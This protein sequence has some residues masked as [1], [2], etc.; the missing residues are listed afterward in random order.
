MQYLLLYSI[1]EELLLDWQAVECL[2][3]LLW[4]YLCLRILAFA[5]F[6]SFPYDLLHLRERLVVVRPDELDG[7]HYWGYRCHVALYLDR[8]LVKHIAAQAYRGGQLHRLWWL[9][10]FIQTVVIPGR[11]LL[12]F[13]AVTVEPQRLKVDVR[14]VVGLGILI[15]L[16]CKGYLGQS[17]LLAVRRGVWYACLVLLP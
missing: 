3:L 2:F 14:L 15:L 4:R 17:F 12:A 16:L 6:F 1:N 7:M 9:W 10:A 8:Y 5:H 11:H 13:Y